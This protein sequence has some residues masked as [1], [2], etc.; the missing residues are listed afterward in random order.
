MI[1]R[2]EPVVAAIEI[3]TRLDLYEFR[4]AFENIVTAK[5]IKQ[6]ALG[7]YG[8]I[9]GA[10]FGFFSNKIINTASLDTWFKDNL[11]FKTRQR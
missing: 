10:V 2:P 7:H 11:V 1:V 4:K 9:F 3:K 5:K 8:H 6:L